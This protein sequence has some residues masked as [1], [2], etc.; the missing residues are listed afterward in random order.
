M[1]SGMLTNRRDLLADLDAV[2]QALQQNRDE[3]GFEQ[4]R[5]PGG[6]VDVRRVVVAGDGAGDGGQ[7]ERLRGEDAGCWSPANA[8]PTMA[9][10]STRTKAAISVTIL[11][12]NWGS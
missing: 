10:C 3:D 5:Q 2:H 4:Q 1:E 7:Q 12:P 6:D 8:A 11:S 9:I